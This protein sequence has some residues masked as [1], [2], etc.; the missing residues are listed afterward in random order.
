MS[1]KSFKIVLD[2][3]SFDSFTG[4]TYTNANY[5]VDLTRVI[6][7]PEDYKK[8]YYMYCTFASDI[9]TSAATGIVSTNMYTLSFN[10]SNKVN[11]IY[12]YK[13]NSLY[14]FI[15]PVQ[16]NPSDNGA[17]S[18]HV[19]FFLQDKD[20]RPIFINDLLNVTNITINVLQNGSFCTATAFYVCILTFVQCD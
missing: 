9:D 6:R 12:Q 10:L 15:L 13:N 3:T 2:S 7:E 1:K 14:S 4:G 18:P 16:V 19:G 8:T 17:G 20:Q 11:N 5:F